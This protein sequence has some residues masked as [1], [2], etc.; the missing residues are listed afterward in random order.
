MRDSGLANDFHNLTRQG[1]YLNITSRCDARCRHCVVCGTT[2]HA[3]DMTPELV[4]SIV[5][6]MPE[7]RIRNIHFVGGEPF[8]VK[9]SLLEYLQ[10]ASRLGIR[11]NI[12]TNASWATSKED[13]LSLMKEF[14][15][16]DI[17]TVSS[18]K[19]HLEYIDS[20]FVKYAIHAGVETKKTV[21]LNITYVDSL[22]CREVKSLYRDLPKSVIIQ[23]VKAMPFDD[24]ESDSIRRVSYYDFP[25]K[26]SR[27][28]W[29]GNYYV[30]QTGEV[31]ACCQATASDNSRYL[32]LGNISNESL[33]AMAKKVEDSK[34]CQFLKAHGV[35]GL[36]QI[37]K[38]TPYFY[39]LKNKWFASSCE[40]CVFLLDDIDRLTYILK[41]LGK[42]ML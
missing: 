29:L 42:D 31:T 40:L 21:L 28:C 2:N 38:D 3:S 26:A 8:L 17:L 1:I 25:E 19:Y 12:I 37:I 16:L 24:V 27:I 18:D 10:R 20:R 7:S 36:L 15:A 30:G 6:Q 22:E 5:S 39:E 41:K 32:Y 13:A 11:S 9:D 33:E 35:N 14:S 4:N 23:T 34:L